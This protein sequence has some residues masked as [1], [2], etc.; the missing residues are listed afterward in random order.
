MGGFKSNNSPPKLSKRSSGRKKGENGEGEVRSEK[1]GSEK[2]RRGKF[3]HLLIS[4]SFV[5]ISSFCSM[6]NHCL[7]RVC[8]LDIWKIL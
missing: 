2:E 4:F 8:G 1:G 7:G 5:F 3:I 6:R